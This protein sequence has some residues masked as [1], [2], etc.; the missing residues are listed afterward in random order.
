MRTSHQHFGRILPLVLLLVI[1]PLLVPTAV[2]AQAAG[3]SAAQAQAPLP[4]DTFHLPEMVVTANRTATPRALLP[5]SITVIDGTDLR[6]RGVI[7]LLDAL[8]EVPGLHVVRTGSLGAG[9]SVFLRGGNSNFVKVM[10]DGVALNEPGGRFDFGALTLENVERIEVVRGPSSVLDGSDAVA[11]VIQIFTREGRGEPVLSAALQGGSLGTFRAEAGARG[12][13]DRLDYTV[14]AGR[15]D[16]DGF[17]PVNNRFT[18]LTGS[19]R[20]AI[21]PDDRSDLAVALRFQESRYHFPTD[22]SG[23]ISDLNQFTFDDAVNLSIEGGRVLTPTLEARLLL[24]ASLAERGAEN[25]PDSPAD[26]IGFGYRSQRLGT[27]TR[28]GADA[29]LTWQRDALSATGGVDWEVERE[30]LH[31][32]TESNFGGGPSVSADSF[33]QDRWNAAAYSQLE[34]GGPAGSLL[35]LGAR[36]DRNQVYGEFLTGQAGVVVPVGGAGRI[37]GSVGS[38]YKAPTFSQQFARTPFEVGN[39]DLEPEESRSWEI[40][41]DGGFLGNRLVLGAAWFSQEFR[42]LIEYSFRGT[43]APSYWNENLARSSGAE[44][45][46]RWQSAGG[47]RVGAEYSRV[48]ARLLEEGGESVG[49]GSEPRLLRRPARK[50][51]AHVRAPLVLG[52]SGG[53]TVN[54]VGSRPDND[55]SSWPAE[56]VTL[57]AY[58]TTDLDLQLPLAGAGGGAGAGPI[59]LTLRVENLFDTEYQTVVGFP[60][61]GRMILVGVRW[62]P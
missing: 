56:R 12:A 20:L 50:V 14:S 38:A 43:D 55:F 34:A 51:S 16:S 27:A 13:T 29:R 61:V 5:Q 11:G 49:E 39:P 21:P 17:Y 46:V 15:T 28:R 7:F 2:A 45:S 23:E 6:S 62:N 52:A 4:A 37:R 48:N 57:P 26:T 41:W 40:G 42:N 9:T 18:A 22:G 58:T 36:L 59:L 24:R 47:M 10:L 25:E 60:G 35:S 54:Q 30:R 8:E 33:R 44:V 31:T 1:T 19:G 3:Q 32:R 53:L